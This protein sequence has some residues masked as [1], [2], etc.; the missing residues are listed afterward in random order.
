[1]IFSPILRVSGRSIK[2]TVIMSKSK[3]TPPSWTA[4]DIPPLR[5]RSAVITGTG[6]LG[7]Q[8][9]LELARAGAEVIIAGRNPRKGDEAISAILGKVP[10]ASVRF[11]QVDLA[12]L[13]S[14]EDFANRLRNQRTSLDLLINNAAVMMPP[15]RLDTMDGFELQFGTN[16]LGHFA[17]TARLMPLLSTGN[18][19]RVVTLSSIAARD[20][21][22]RFSDLQS[23]RNYNP[24]AAYAQSKLACLI[25]AFE[26]QRR[27]DAGKW[28]VS[29]IAAH[30]GISRTDLLHNGP[31]R[32]SIH[33][34]LRTFLWFLFQPVAQGALPT[35][36]AATS[37]QAHGGGYYG[38]AGFGETR[39]APADA[40]IPAQA[41][42]ID[43]ASSLWETSARLAGVSFPDAC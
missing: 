10:S 34:L 21:G 22:I 9:A 11:E 3:T 15:K 23:E 26:L 43:S 31:G 17:L 16:Y 13:W 7:L 42:D 4:A 36:F 25:F 14:I 2:N 39:G 18:D 32:A 20:G 41:L 35:L 30:P 33:G 6:G 40:A 24:M 37:P 38:P 1:M 29:S 12:S 19:P 5:N 27:S 8:T 28:G